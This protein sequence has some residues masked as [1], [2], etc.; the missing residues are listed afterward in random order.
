MKE[1][2]VLD[3]LRDI[4]N[5]L[6]KQ[7]QKVAKF[8]IENSEKVINL[9]IKELATLSKTSEAT[10]IR[11][12]KK[13]GVEGFS[14]LKIDLAQ[15][16][17]NEFDNRESSKNLR[18]ETSTLELEKNLKIIGLDNIK[19]IAKLLP[20]AKTVYVISDQPNMLVA[21]YMQMMFSEKGLNIISSISVMHI[22]PFIDI[23][24][25][26]DMC[27]FIVDSEDEEIQQIMRS[28]Q[29]K[30]IPVVALTD[31]PYTTLMSKADYVMHSQRGW[32]I[33]IGSKKS[34]LVKFFIIDWLSK[35]IK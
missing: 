16:I 6:Y 30:K 25:K 33:E 19:R 21:D 9:S 4:Y 18:V 14:Q 15:A 3:N 10:I 7:E 17:T 1:N 5:N 26:S 11:L 28:L 24:T 22:Q 12:S 29:I 31:F 35:Y 2:T 23:M 20:E 13:V 27:I 8:I 34:L 32:A